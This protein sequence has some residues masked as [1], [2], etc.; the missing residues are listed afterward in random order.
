M[1]INPQT[2]AHYAS[3]QTEATTWM[4]GGCPQL[5]ESYLEARHHAAGMYI[6]AAIQ[7]GSKG[8]TIIQADVSGNHN[9]Q[10]ATGI[11]PL[12]QSRIPNDHLPTNHD[13]TATSVPDMTLYEKIKRGR[14][15]KRR[16]TH[17]RGD[18]ILHRHKTRTTTDLCRPTINTLASFHL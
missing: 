14:I 15:I 13:P 10:K 18:K 5:T 16:Y 1:D 9:K 3:N 8:G 2:S 6:L 4:A 11:T 7:A 12:L 17:D